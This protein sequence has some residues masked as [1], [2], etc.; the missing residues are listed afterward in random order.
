MSK[1]QAIYS[2]QIY[3]GVYYQ[4][5]SKEDAD[6]EKFV[7]FMTQREAEYKEPAKECYNKTEWEAFRENIEP[8][9]PQIEEIDGY[10]AEKES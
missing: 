3:D 2:N 7:S 5:K 8:P 9:T 1:Q 4:N 6:K 10:K